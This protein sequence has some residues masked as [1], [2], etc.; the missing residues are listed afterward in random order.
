MERQSMVLVGDD[1]EEI[2]IRKSAEYHPTVWGDYFIRNY[3]CLP[4][5]EEKE[6]MIKR[7]EELKDGVR[8]LF[9]ETHDGLQIMILVDSIQ[10]LGLDYHFDKEITAALRLIYEA[11]VENYGLYE[12][13]LRFRLL[14]QHGYTSSPDVFNK[15]KDDK[16]RFLSALN[17]DAKGLLGLYNAA[18]LGTHEEMI[19]DEAISFTKCQLESMLDELEP[20]LATEVSL[21]LETPLYPRT[22]RFLVRKYIPIYQEK[23]MRNDTI[24]EL[25]KLDFNLLQSLHQEEVKKITIWWNDLALTESL[26]FARD[27]VVECYY[28]IVGVY[29]EPQYSHPRIITCK[30]ISL[31]SIMDDIYDN[32]ST[33]EESR[34]LTEAIERWE[35]QAVE[36][37]PEYLKD[38]YLKLL[39]TYKD[40]E[41]ELEP[42]KKYRIPYLHK[43]IKDLSR[44]YFQ[45]AKW[46]AEGYVPTL[47][48][49]LRVSL[50][51]TGYPAITCVSFV[52]LGEDAT[53][54][55]FEWVTSFPKIL[56]SCTIICRLMDDIASHEREQER[57]HV[58][59]TV[60]S[61]MKEYGTSTKVA[62]EKLQVVVEQAWKDLNKECLRPTTQVAR[63]LIEIILNLSRTMEDIYKYNDTYTNS[64]TR[65][66]DNISLILVESFPI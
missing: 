61:Y 51:S 18:Y 48:E 28:W 29:F 19:L 7:V 56:K 62:H 49:H 15:F 40:F 25:A 4:I 41:D 60:E 63:S 55:A 11:D 59:S 30:V 14:R 9:E 44:S 46:C 58:A 16:G 10:L 54:E 52:G 43:E 66:K 42:N 35:P 34:L 20:P 6:Y 22:R 50:K 27:R 39:K 37:V 45:E 65:M 24:L 23:V 21:F 26:K 33:L 17:G 13:S 12:V 1:K 32:Y 57:D 31:M 47:E 64:N 38:F 3:S 36:H 8:N 5:E 2:I 53:K